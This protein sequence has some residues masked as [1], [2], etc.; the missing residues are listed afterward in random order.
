[1]DTHDHPVLDPVW[2]L[3]ARATTLCGVTATLL[4]WDDKIPSFDEVHQEALK[5][6]A[7][8]GGARTALREKK[9]ATP[10]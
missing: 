4:E 2:E 10:R 1:L 5:A 9:S 7:F 8:I 3:Y 6:N